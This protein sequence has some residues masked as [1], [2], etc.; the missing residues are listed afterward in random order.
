MIRNFLNRLGK[1]RGLRLR[2]LAEVAAHK[3]GQVFRAAVQYLRV[4]AVRRFAPRLF[5]PPRFFGL[6][7]RAR[8]FSLDDWRG[9]NRLASAL[10]NECGMGVEE[11]RRDADRYCE[12]VFDLLGSGPVELEGPVDWHKDFKSGARWAP[13]YFRRIKEIELNDASD[14]KV[15]W[16]LSRFYQAVPLGVAYWVTGDEKYAREFVAQT[17]NW[18]ESNPPYHGVNWHCAMEV[19]IRSINWIWGYYFFRHSRHLNPDV[20]SRIASSLAVHGE[21]IWNNLEFDKRILGGRYVRHNGN[22]FLSDLVG[23]I[24]LGLVL[25]GARAKQWLT[26]AVDELDRE[27][28]IQVLSD[29]AHWELSPAYHRLV[30]E[31]VLPAVIL[32]SQNDIVVP[33]TLR[34]ACEMMCEYT[35]HFLKPDGRCPLVR[36]ADDGRVCHFDKAEYRDHRHLLA[37]AG[38]FLG[39]EDFVRRA[40]RVSGEILWM[41]GPAGITRGKAMAGPAQELASRAFPDAGFYVLRD[42]EQLHVFVNC[43]DIGMKGTYGGHAHNDCLGFE[44]YYGGTTFISDC[45]TFNYSGDPAGRNAFRATAS[46]NTARVDGLEINRF[47][48]RALF[49]MEND[50]RPKVLDWRTEPHFDYL[51]AEHFG[52]TRLPAPVIHR[53]SFLLDRASQCLILEDHFRGSGRHLFELFFHF[54]PGIEVEL[55]SELKFQAKACGSTLLLDFAGTGNWA[56]RLERGWVSERYGTKEPAWKLVLSSRQIVTAS[57]TTAIHFGEGL[58]LKWSG[59]DLERT[60]TA[61]LKMCAELV[62]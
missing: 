31:L 49:G 11:I 38:V 61:A 44:L 47:S 51:R 22:H 15:P 14:I 18:I 39:R 12:H 56:A 7:G 10:A 19:A 40:G 24:Y 16:E 34:R 42:G 26:W 46:H 45:G 57:L 28:Q 3:T 8:F 1:L 4:C 32:C 41:L 29:G 25:P 52:Y 43:A 54:L 17:G 37:L 27:M 59:G 5:P 62:Q 58:K 33:G 9:S 55:V 50:A 23:L 2:E 21:Y 13:R 6:D 35:M 60:R 48:E 30:L 53:R 36:D 20:Q